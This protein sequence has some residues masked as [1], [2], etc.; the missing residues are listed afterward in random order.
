MRRR[1][2][3]DDMIGKGVRVPDIQRP[4]TQ[5]SD[6]PR[7]LHYEHM[8]P[9]TWRDLEMKLAI[10]RRFH[11]EVRFAAM[12]GDRTL[13][14]QMVQQGIHPYHRQHGWDPFEGTADAMDARI[15]AS[16]TMSEAE[17]EH[18]I[19]LARA[20]I[21]RGRRQYEEAV[22]DPQSIGE[23]VARAT[24]DVAGY[25]G[26]IVGAGAGLVAGAITAPAVP[27]APL[28]AAAAG[29]GAG[30]VLGQSVGEGVARGAMNLLGVESRRHDEQ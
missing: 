18:L 22:R 4:Y 27:G 24:G 16:E 1:P 20:G 25:G 29:A 10:A 19:Q 12:K 3:L 14:A 5:L 23:R 28:V 8:S 9:D 7:V 21:A 17:R 6:D 13:G 2:V 15:M 26:R 11:D 30:G